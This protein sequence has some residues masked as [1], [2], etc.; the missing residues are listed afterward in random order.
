[1]TAS[2]TY[3]RRQSMWTN[4]EKQR[5]VGLY[6]DH[7]DKELCAILGKTQGQLRGMKSIL[8]LNQKSKPFTDEEKRCI[9]DFY[10]LHPDEMDLESFAKELGRQKTSI[11]R[12]ARKVGLTNYNRRLTEEQ[13]EKNNESHRLL[14]QSEY[15]KECIAPSIKESLRKWHATH[16]HP[17]G[18]SGKHHTPD[19]CKRISEYQKAQWAAKSDE[20]RREIRDRLH[21]W[22]I[23]HGHTSD[24]NTYSRCRRG[25]REDLGI[26]FRSRWEANIARLLNKFNILWQYEPHRF[27]YPDNEDGILSYCPDFYLPD[28]DI[29]LEIKGWMDETSIKRIAMFKEYYP[30]EYKKLVIVD[31]PL[32]LELEKQYAGDIP[33]WEYKKK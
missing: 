1:M 4:E 2:V 17:R 8:G 15:Y 23:Q 27:K 19:A 22:Q 21:T 18:M 13:K 9:I 7:N 14:Y 6:P 11:S 12:Y 28:S 3:I 24:E 26:F 33:N 20:E 31:E 25:I 16:E 30:E 10:T 29:W 32:Y 5:L